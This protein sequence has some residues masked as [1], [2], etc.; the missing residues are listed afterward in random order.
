MKYTESLSSL[1]YDREQRYALVGNEQFLKESFVRKTKE[2]RPDDDIAEFYPEQYEEALSYAGSG[3]LFSRRVMILWDFDKMPVSK[4][5]DMVFDG[6]VIYVMT[7]KANLKSRDITKIFSTVAIVECNKLKEYGAEYPSWILSNITEAGYKAQEGVSPFLFSRVGPDM[8]S[9]MNELEKL[10]IVKNDKIITLKDVDT[11]VSV[12]AVSTSFE[13][14]ENLLRKD[15]K[16]VLINFDTFSK[17]QDNFIDITGFLAVYLEKMYRILLLHE[18]KVDVKDIADI[19]GMPFFLVK[20]KYLPRITSLGRNYIASKINALCD[21]D[22]ALRL[23]K[24]DKRI[25]MERY[26]LSFLN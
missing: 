6:L 2:F 11:Y 16:K 10:F 25:I 24:G 18:K 8:H 3:T 14:F 9:I 12:L 20:T 26:F 5:E 19:V 4:F 13:L 15:V 21:V 1:K 7:E 22:V 17:L 23:F